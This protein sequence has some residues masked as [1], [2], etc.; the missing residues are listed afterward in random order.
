M[1]YVVMFFRRKL[2]RGPK[3]SMEDVYDFMSSLRDLRFWNAAKSAFPILRGGDDKKLSL[4]TDAY[5]VTK[6]I[7]ESYVRK[8]Q[9][10]GGHFTDP[11]NVT[12]IRNTVNLLLSIV[13]VH[14]HDHNESLR[15]ELAKALQRMYGSLG[16]A[17]S[18]IV[19]HNVP[20]SLTLVRLGC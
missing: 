15:R 20:A 13:I 10:T 19:L 2:Y 3:P 11:S 4:E 12:N 17:I 8:V 5:L 6:T 18:M 1:I 7:T 14:S 9:H 16:K